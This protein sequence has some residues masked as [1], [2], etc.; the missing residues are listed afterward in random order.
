MVPVLWLDVPFQV[1]A[2]RVAND[3]NGRP[4]PL[5]DDLASAKDLYDGRQGWYQDTATARI[6]AGLEVDQVVERILAEVS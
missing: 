5:F 1:A 3:V 6:D 4:R 2:R